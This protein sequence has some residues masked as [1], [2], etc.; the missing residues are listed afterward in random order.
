MERDTASLIA[1]ADLS[2]LLNPL[3]RSPIGPGNENRPELT[4]ASAPTQPALESRGMGNRAGSGLFIR[5]D[6]AARRSTRRSRVLGSRAAPGVRNRPSGR[7]A[8]SVSHHPAAQRGRRLHLVAGVE[9][10]LEQPD[11]RLIPDHGLPRRRLG[12]VALEDTSADLPAVLDGGG[13]ELV[14]QSLSP[15]ALAHD[16]AG[17]RPDALEL[18]VHAHPRLLPGPDPRVVLPRLDR[19]PAGR[20]AVDVAHETGC[21]AARAAAGLR[22]ERSVSLVLSR[23]APDPARDLERLAAALGG[24]T[25]I[26]HGLDVRGR[27]VVGR[28]PAELGHTSRL[29]V[30]LGTRRDERPPVG[31]H[32]QTRRV[33]RPPRIEPSGDVVARLGSTALALPDAYEEDAWTGIRWRV[34]SK[35]FAHVLVAQEGYTS[36]YRDVTGVTEPTTVLTFRSSG[37]ELS[38]LVNAG[39]PFY[40]PP[41]SP[42]VVGMVLDDDTDWDEVAELVTESYRFCAPHTLRR[43]L[44]Q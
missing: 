2:P 27:R 3:H 26:E 13:G 22:Q 35:T 4:H 40:R 41:W 44:D 8:E 10:D 28:S 17:D 9:E 31:V 19:D 29:V 5:S 23:V 38:A 16:E 42:T 32:W 7:H 39:P 37:E 25:G 36:A 33:S 12:G 15:E 24:A 20:L 14:H 21:R 34:R 11:R 18:G 6:E 43:R 30:A 1:I